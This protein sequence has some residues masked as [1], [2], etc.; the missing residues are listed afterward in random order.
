[1]RI[2][3][4]ERLVGLSKKAIRLYESCGLLTVERVP[5]GYREYTDADVAALKQIKL[6]RL[7]GVSISDIKLLRHGILPMEELLN[8]RKKTELATYHF[9]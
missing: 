6:L 2:S 9:S 1:M 7:A 3:E 4:V 5:N 8:K